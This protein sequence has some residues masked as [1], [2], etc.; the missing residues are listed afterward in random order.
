MT[1]LQ[2][3]IL[4][5][6]VSLP[7][8]IIRL[9]IPV[10]NFLLPS[11]LL[12]ALILLCVS[13]SAAK[14]IQEGADLGKLRTQFDLPVLLFLLAALLSVA[15][16]PDI[17]GGLGILKAFFIEPVLFFYSIVYVF[18]QSKRQLVYA[19]I[20]SAFW[21][22][23]LGVL[24][25]ITGSFSLAPRELAQ[26]RVTAVYNS[27][28]SYS[29]FIGPVVFLALAGFLQSKGRWRVL[30]FGLATLF[31]VVIFWTRSRGGLAGEAAAIMTFIFMFLAN[32][33]VKLRRFWPVLP[34]SF[35]LLFGLFFYQLFATYN[36]VNSLLLSSQAPEDTLQVR[37]ELWLGTLNLIKDHPFFG[38][39][40]NG[41]K[42]LYANQ[43]KLSVYQE[44]LQY[45]HNLVL[46]FWA[47]TGVL[48]LVAF[49]WIVVKSFKLLGRDTLS[50]K[51][52]WLSIGLISALVYSLV[53]GMADVPYFKND[54][55]AQFFVL[56]GLIELNLR[57]RKS[58]G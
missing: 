39:G 43:Y 34:L 32:R 57:S 33:V 55:S 11:T 26:G 31:T 58:G 42:T 4:I 16:S 38:A 56:L 45:P 13:L 28:N 37:Y 12:E 41:F 40:L 19:L 7:L 5:T 6:I 47:E 27:A 52:S 50:V 44:D 51:N 15:I 2:A 48:G 30:Y 8:Y 23:G 22:S 21:L 46:N 17:R 49:C 20:F 35:V 18:R 29:L 24:Q 14:F 10:G 25:K 3:L 53:H 9:E 54:L 36:P 1:K